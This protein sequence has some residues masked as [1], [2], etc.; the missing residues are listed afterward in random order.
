MSSDIMTFIVRIILPTNQI[1]LVLSLTDLNIGVK[2]FAIGV[3]NDLKSNGN[4]EFAEELENLLNC[5]YIICWGRRFPIKTEFINL[6]SKVEKV[7]GKE[8][9]VF[10]LEFTN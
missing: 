5:K 2:D 7:E 6:I 10:E 4:E 9:D 3:L 8:L 1:K